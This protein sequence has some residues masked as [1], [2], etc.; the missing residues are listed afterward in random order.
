M[1]LNSQLSLFPSL[2][3]DNPL[4]VRTWDLTRQCLTWKC[5]VSEGRTHLEKMLNANLPYLRKF[6]H[7]PHI[8][9]KIRTEFFDY[10]W[11]ILGLKQ[12]LISE[13][14]DRKLV[15]QIAEYLRKVPESQLEIR[16]GLQ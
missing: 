10:T 2:G 6:Q 15:K 9:S 16:V 1:K 11:R 3:Y 4:I 7:H 8:Q 13:C 5:P 14:S 12:V